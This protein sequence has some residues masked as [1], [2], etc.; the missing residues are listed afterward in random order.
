MSVMEKLKAKFNIARSGIKNFLDE[1]NANQQ[2]TAALEAE[3]QG[4]FSLGPPKSELKAGIPSA[5]EDRRTGLLQRLGEQIVRRLGP[6]FEQP[7]G[8]GPARVVPGNLAGLEELSAVELLLLLAPQL[9]V[10]GLQGLAD[11]VHYQEGSPMSE[12]PAR[13]AAIAE[14][15]RTLE[16]ELVGLHDEAAPLGITI[17]LPASERFKRFRENRLKEQERINAA[18]NK[19]TYGPYRPPEP[20]Q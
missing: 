3:R 15:I 9:V 14:E 17:E 2:R 16:A 13:L 5:V 10:S 1:V 19:R 18:M 4:H 11:A 6:R 12:R 20:P 8:E 7:A